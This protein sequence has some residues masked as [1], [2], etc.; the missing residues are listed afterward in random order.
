MPES[1]IVSSDLVRL[2]HSFCSDPSVGDVLSFYFEAT[3]FFR[4]SQV[5]LPFYLG[6][7]NRNIKNETLSR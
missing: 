7:N 4:C 6:R 1:H 3:Y 5:F 2:S